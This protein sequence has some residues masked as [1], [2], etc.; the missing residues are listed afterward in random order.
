MKYSLVMLSCSFL[1]PFYLEANDL[2]YN[3]AIN[4]SFGN[5]YD[6]YSFSENRIDLNLFY[7][8]FQSWIQYEYSNPPDI[9]FPINDIR[10]F[11]IE[12]DSQNLLIKLGDIYEIWGRGLTLNQMDDQVTNFDNG[13]RGFFF[14]YNKG[15]FLISHINGNS[16]IWKLGQDLRIPI[17]NDKHNM[18]A[19]RVH[20]EKG[21][22]TI[23]L[24]YLQSHEEHMKFNTR[25]IALVGHK[26]KGLYTS[27]SLDN[28]DY[29]I[30]YVDKISTEKGMFLANDSLKKGHGL[31]GN[32]NI[33]L[34]NWGLSTEYKRYDFDTFHSDQTADDYGNQIPYQQ[35]P[36]LGKEQNSTLLGRLSH[37]Y[38]FNDERGLQYEL[39]GSLFGL[40]ANVQYAHLSRNETWQ[41]LDGPFEW[42][43]KKLNGYLPSNDISA[44]PYYENYQEL[45]GYALKDRIYFKIGRGS[46]K[47]I[48]GTKWYFNGSQSD[49]SFK[50]TLDYD[51][52]YSPYAPDY[53]II[54]IDSLYDTTLINYNVN[55][56]NWS[57]SKSYTIPLEI[58]YI[59]DNSL[60][61]GIGFQYQERTLF[62]KRRGNVDSYNIGQS[63]WVMSDPENPNEEKYSKLSQFSFDGQIKNTQYNRLF[64]LT[65]SKAPKWSFTIT[66]DWTNAYEVQSTDPYY[67]P[68]E[69]FVFGDLKYFAGKRNNVKPP[70]FIQ[71]K[72]VSA[73]FIYNLTSSQRISVM[74]GS[75]RGGLFCSNGVCRLI[76]P[77]NDGLKIGYSASF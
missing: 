12:Y 65:I 60:T 8:N 51:T 38:N 56:K 54:S 45:S 63:K 49:T 17:Y 44:L 11:R 71:K 66:Q 74:Y 43:S 69:A 62:E 77:F 52:T 39:N 67:N 58:N 26:T 2:N 20:Y 72:W 57:E 32:Y 47:E 75:I 18:V 41:S 73:E 5:S 15:P 36:T 55:A 22:K 61:I 16:D 23:G 34:G 76:P 13:V 53:P 9:G 37:N 21:N 33:Y 24:I 27:W 46:N 19:N 3:S 10:K 64:Y 59:M 40:S 50:L 35:S 70:S 6:F 4:S 14:E 30:E 68:L 42:S 28:M 31:Y 29:F 1:V 7:K 25:D 48:L